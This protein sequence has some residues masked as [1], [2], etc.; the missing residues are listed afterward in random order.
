M[1]VYKIV[2]LEIKNKELFSRY[3]KKVPE[4]VSR[5]GG[6]YIIRGGK[7][8][9]IYGGWNPERIIMVEFESVEM[10]KKCYSSP[11]YLKIAPFREQST[12]SKAIVVEGV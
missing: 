10:L 8:T 7:I 9:P 4:I 11:E 6:R 3:A 12:N 5:Y 2:E 1:S